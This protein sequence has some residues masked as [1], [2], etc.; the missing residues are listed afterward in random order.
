M[1]DA[2]LAQLRDFLAALPAD[3]ARL[4]RLAEAGGGEPAALFLHE[5]E[6]S[7]AGL[8]DSDWWLDRYTEWALSPDKPNPFRDK[9]N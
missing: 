2:H 7:P 6:W 9:T 4:V 1:G 8:V 3:D 5:E